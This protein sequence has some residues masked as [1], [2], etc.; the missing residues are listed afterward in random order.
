[1]YPDISYN[2]LVF[3]DAC[4]SQ[5]ELFKTH[6]GDTEVK[7]TKELVL[8]F[9]NVFDFEWAAKN[10]LNPSDLAE[11]EKV[12]APAWAE[13]VKVCAP[14]K[15]EYEK[16]RAPALAEYKKVCDQAWAEYDKV[17]VLKFYELY[18]KS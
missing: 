12:S 3:K 6:F 9:A 5:R 2:L 4:T 10:L 11:Y 18:T 13:Y 17:S 1:M 15:A 7:L 14:A 8:K 16:V